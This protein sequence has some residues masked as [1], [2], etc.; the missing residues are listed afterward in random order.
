MAKEFFNKNTDC[1]F[2]SSLYPPYFEGYNIINSFSFATVNYHAF[3]LVGEPVITDKA[4]LAGKIIGVIRDSDTWNYEKKFAIPN[5]TYVKISNLESLIGLLYKKRVDV[6]IHDDLEFLAVA[7]LLKKEMANYSKET[8]VAT[9]K[10]VIT[11]H[12]N[13]KT[14]SYIDRINPHIKK[15]LKDGLDKYFNQSSIN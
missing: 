8:P 7:A 13:E 2:P 12:N 5:V 4:Q 10:I 11:C 1:L 15:M 3:T 6:V 14:Q 9:D